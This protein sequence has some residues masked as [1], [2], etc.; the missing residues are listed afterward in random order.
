M[1]GHSGDAAISIYSTICGW[2]TANCLELKLLKDRLGGLSVLID[3]DY[4]IRSIV[5]FS[6]CGNLVPWRLR[7]IGNSKYGMCVDRKRGEERIEGFRFVL[8]DLLGIITTTAIQVI[9]FSLLH[10]LTLIFLKKCGR[11]LTKFWIHPR[12]VSLIRNLLDFPNKNRQTKTHYNFQN[13]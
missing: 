8:Q 6:S 7:G 10:Q 5:A 4:L 9:P 3:E 12:Y 13:D 1:S 11:S 2:L